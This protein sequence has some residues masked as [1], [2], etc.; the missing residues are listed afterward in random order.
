LGTHK[1][2]KIQLEEVN[3]R[4]SK[5]RELLLCG[6]IE[7]DDYRTIKAESEERI[8]RLEVKLS[9]SVTDTTNIEP[10][11]KGYQQHFGIGCFV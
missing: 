9:A 6:D 1:Q 7:A 8:N 3:N 5:T 11:W 2:L 4:L 10:L